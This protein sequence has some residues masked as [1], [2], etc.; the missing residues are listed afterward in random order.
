MSKHHSTCNIQTM[1]GLDKVEPAGFWHCPVELT[2]A[3]T[4]HNVDSL[5]QHAMEFK[6]T[7]GP[8]YLQQRRRQQSQRSMW[9]YVSAQ[10]MTNLQHGE[11]SSGKYTNVVKSAEK[12]LLKDESISGHEAAQSII[13]EIFKN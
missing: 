4:D 10:I 1:S 9:K 12:R 13:N 5:W 7:M 8:E 11:G 2:S 6:D 3:E